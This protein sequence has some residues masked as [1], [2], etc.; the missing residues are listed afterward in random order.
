MI[1]FFSGVAPMD[2]VTHL[3][4]IFRRNNA[5][6]DNNVTFIGYGLGTGKV[7]WFFSANHVVV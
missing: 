1:L 2:E 3:R 7:V 6:L 4:N 5:L